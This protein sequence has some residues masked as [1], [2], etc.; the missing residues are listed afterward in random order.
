M[1][2]SS[3][4]EVAPESERARSIESDAGAT[5]GR[6]SRA[7]RDAP[8]YDLIAGQALVAVF[9]VLTLAAVAASVT[10]TDGDAAWAL[11]RGV[12]VDVYVYG[13][14]GAM[15]RTLLVFVTDVDADTDDEQFLERS[16]IE[17]ARLGLRLFGALCLAA[18]VYLA[19]GALDDAVV[20]GTAPPVPLLAG[21]AFVAGFYVERAYAALGIVADRLLSLS[22]SDDRGRQSGA[23]EGDDGGNEPTESGAGDDSTGSS[24]S[25]ASF[26]L[27]PP[28]RRADQPLWFRDWRS[29]TLFALGLAITALAVV[30]TIDS[31]SIPFVPT[32]QKTVPV[33]VYLYAFLGA[34]G[35]VFTT[36]F[37]EFDK[38]VL[39]L[40]QKG[41][42]VPAA[43]LLAAGFYLFSFL[44]VESATTPPA[45]LL[46]GLAFL[47]GLYVNVALV[48]LD[49]IASRVFARFEQ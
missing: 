29:Q 8:W 9:V 39:S 10:M 33:D 47:I 21:T 20:I 12:P 45:G 34:M 24:Q 32:V 36:L 37:A 26:V 3:G 46:A 44:F 1:T 31:T 2:S 6:E 35:Y 17:V 13:F 40:L 18:G 15:A 38:G 4:G 22:E 11:D 43:L 48:S 28:Q 14:L 49:G 7:I 42:R 41:V 19:S 23:A 25:L 30:A 16:W 5:G 27:F